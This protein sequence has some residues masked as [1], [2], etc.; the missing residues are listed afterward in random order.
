[1]KDTGERVIPEYMKAHNGMLLEHIERY[2]FAKDY[3]CGRVLDL[4]C[5]VGYGADILLEEIYDQKLEEYV[6]IDLSADAIAYAKEMYGFQKTTFEQ[7]NALD[8]N[9][10]NRYGTFD[11]ILSFE[12]IEHIEED[13]EFVKNLKSLLKKNGTLVIS[14]PFGKGRAVPCASPFHIRQY[15]QEEFMEILVDAG[16]KVKLFCQR[17]QTIEKPKAGEKYYLMVAVCELRES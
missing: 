10:V 5:G 7:A 12:T 9:L 17:G 15:R 16:F 8:K 1:M 3:A 13:R 14:T 6:G 2:E 11:S 4:A